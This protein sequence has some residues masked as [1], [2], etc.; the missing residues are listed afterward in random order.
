MTETHSTIVINDRVNGIT[1]SG[2]IVR[3]G[4]YKGFQD[5]ANTLTPKAREYE[6]VVRWDGDEFDS[7]VSFARLGLA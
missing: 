7:L 1:P 4:T 3:T 5:R 6:A 2:R